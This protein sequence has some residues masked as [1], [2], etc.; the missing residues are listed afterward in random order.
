MSGTIAITMAG[1]GSRF[2][3][4]GYNGPKFAITVGGHPLFDWS[5]FGLLGYR[6]AGWRFSFATRAEDEAASFIRERCA[7]LGIS[8]A[9]IIELPELTDG[10]ATTALHLARQA[11]MTAPLA[12]FNIDTFVAPGTMGPERIPS[13]CAGWV[14]CFPGLGD[15]WSFARA[16]T[17]GKILELREKCRISDDATT[18]FY[19]FASAGLYCGLYERFFGSGQGAE[20]GERYIAPMYNSL[21]EEGQPVMLHRIGLQDIGMLG[22]PEQV[23]AFAHNPPDG[24]RPFWQEPGR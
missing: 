11:D 19:Y 15:G 8:V 23:T 4:A 3:A 12:I 6:D 2:R 13:G 14:P 10:Q 21:I 20:K 17:Q 9:A 7:R 16:D 22:T 5:M 18:G 1:M 24:A